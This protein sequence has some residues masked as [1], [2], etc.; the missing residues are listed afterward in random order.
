MSLNKSLDRVRQTDALIRKKAA[1]NASGLAEKLH[2]SRAGVY[3]WI[4]QMKEEGF[5]IAYCKKEK[6]YI[7]TEK[8]KMVSELF[9]REITR[10]DMRKITGGEKFFQIFSDY[11]YSRQTND[12]FTL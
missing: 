7:Y 12:N 3:N 6:T 5:P 2:L 9:E 1:G 8:G 11:N 4:Q 10:K